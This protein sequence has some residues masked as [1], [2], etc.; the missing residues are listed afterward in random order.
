MEKVNNYYK[1]KRNVGQFNSFKTM[2]EK[3]QKHFLFQQIV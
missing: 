2:A 1:S 3:P